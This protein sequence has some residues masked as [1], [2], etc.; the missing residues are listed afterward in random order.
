MDDWIKKLSEELPREGIQ[1]A[2]AQK[3]K[4]GYDTTGYGYQY[5]VDK[6]NE[7][8]GFDWGFNWE[9]LNIT[10][11][12]FNNGTPFFDITCKV[13]IW[14]GD[15]KARSCVGGHIAK[16]HADA[17]K[18]AI[19]NGFKKV[20]AFWGVGS[21]AFRGEID[22]D[23]KPYPEDNNTIKPKPPTTTDILKGILG[24]KNKVE[25][26]EKKAK[27]F[28]LVKSGLKVSVGDEEKIISAFD[29]KEFELSE[30]MDKKITG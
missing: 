15:K 27:Y 20:A 24:I 6:F 23:N 12:K 13:E 17:L 9:I 2:S 18:G 29:K 26:A 3:T 19:T 1:K 11:G 7:V 16:L 21:S 22:D 30:L 10:N 28:S 5:C 14:V 8:C 25:H 4:K